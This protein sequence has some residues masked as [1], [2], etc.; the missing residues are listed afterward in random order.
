MNNR[1]GLGT[2]PLASPFNPIS[3]PD[4]EK[5]VKE[6]IELGGYYFDT[7]PLYGEGEIEKLLGRVLKDVPRE[8]VY[9]GTKTVKHVD[10]NGNYFMSGKYEDIVKQIDNSLH[11]LNLDYVD[12]LMVHSPDSKV[13]I[14]E[15]LGAMEKL[16]ELG[17]VRELAVS[18][19]NLDE[20]K[21]YNSSKKIKYVQNRFSLINRS[22]SPELEKYLLDNKIFLLPWH[23][24]EIGQLTGLDFKLR[25]GDSREGKVYWNDENQKVVFEWIRNSLAPIAKKLGITIGQLN[26]AWALQ[27][28]F[29]DYVVVG[30]TKS[31]YLKLNLNAND[32]KL[33]KQVLIEIEV[34]YKNL[35]KYI[36]EHYGKTI[37]E[38]RGLNEKYY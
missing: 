15:T 16:Q 13:P 5:L 33:S 22:L 1:V 18:N 28:P 8:R 34:A 6:F 38:F 12:Q 11:R 29:I 19:V 36:R 37:K 35:E 32:I 26:I 9:I 31:E 2:Y 23:L 25:Q 24:L 21:K 4:A 7:A 20:L 3:V 27:Q 14:E 17:K 10:E 30:T